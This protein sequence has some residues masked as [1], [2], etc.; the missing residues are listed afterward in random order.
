MVQPGRGEL[1]LLLRSSGAGGRHL[2]ARHRD[3]L[4]RYQGPL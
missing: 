1:W 3:R 4:H 2:P